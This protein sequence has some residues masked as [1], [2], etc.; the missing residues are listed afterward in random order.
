MGFLTPIV[1]AYGLD[2]GLDINVL[3]MAQVLGIGIS[4]FPYQTP[5][6]IM[7]QSFGAFTGQ[8]SLRVVCI[9]GILSVLVV[10]PLT[11]LYWKL[12]GFLP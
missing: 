6:M 7:A 4:F 5:P 2:K 10:I 8:Q 1:I 12:I 11:I 3:V 9:Y